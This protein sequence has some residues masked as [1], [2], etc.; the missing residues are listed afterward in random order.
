MS[1]PPK[2]NNNPAAGFGL[3]SQQGNPPVHQS[4][5]IA[6]QRTG[7]GM[8]LSP[9]AQPFSTALPVATSPRSRYFGSSP[10]NSSIDQPSSYNSYSQNSQLPSAPI[11][12]TGGNAGRFSPVPSPIRTPASFSW[13][14]SGGSNGYGFESFA[15]HGMSLGGAASAWGSGGNLNGNGNGNGGPQ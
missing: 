11:P 9:T 6:I 7:E 12:A 15:G 8:S 3:Q 1:S 13:V 2:P 5:P 4:G 10:P 14:S